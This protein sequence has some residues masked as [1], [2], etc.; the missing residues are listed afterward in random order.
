MTQLRKARETSVSAISST[1][2][3]VDG[4]ASNPDEST[5]VKKLAAIAAYAIPVDSECNPVFLVSY[6]GSVSFAFQ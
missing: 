2:F 6:Y 1:T 4:T 5:Y 3:L